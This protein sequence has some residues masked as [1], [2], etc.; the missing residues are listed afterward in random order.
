MGAAVC[1][2]D[3][4]GEAEDLVLVGVVVLEDDVGEDVFFGLLAI[5]IVIN[6]ALAIDGDGALMDDVFV[7]TELGDELDDAV[8][9][10]VGGFFGRFW[11]LV[12]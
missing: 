1:V 10:E 8:F 4:V 3:A 12:F 7:F 11:A 5:V 6:L 2:G 9:I